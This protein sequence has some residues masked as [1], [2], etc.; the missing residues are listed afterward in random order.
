LSLTD[1]VSRFIP[2]FAGVQVG[3]DGGGGTLRL[4]APKRPATVHDLLRHTAGMTY[5]FFP[6]C[7]VRDRYAEANMGSRERS[8]AE[9][10]RVLATL[11]L[12]YEP[13]SIFDYSRA[14]DVLGRVLEV[15]GG[16]TLGEHLRQVMFE[17]LGMPDT[18]FHV[19]PPQHH[20]IAETFAIDPDSGDPLAL[21][22][23]RAPVAFES[24][25]GGL[26]SSAADYARFLQMLLGEG[27]VDGVR[28][29]GRKTVQ[30]MASDHLG[31]IPRTDNVAFPGYGFGLGVAVRTHAGLS[32]VAG[33]VGQYGW[34]GAAGTQFFVD[35][36]EDMFAL[37]MVQAPGLHDELGALFR[38][39]V[40]AALDA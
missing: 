27:A 18:A 13:G 9:A 19:P 15:V 37:L 32:T 22:D 21:V 4:A 12:M 33:S 36:A 30:W 40:Y 3:H 8:N 16:A 31:D 28:L 7:P 25:A 38:N 5:E 14:T 26:V 29:L 17:P 1:A 6:P 11:P 35:P 24:G 34:S 2:E 10:A 23:V 20:R 39:G